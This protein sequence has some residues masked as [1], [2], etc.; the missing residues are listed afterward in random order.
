MK[1]K[2]KPLLKALISI[3]DTCDCQKAWGNWKSIFYAIQGECARAVKKSTGM[4]IDEIKA[5]G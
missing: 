1:A 5:N 2:I 4:T 3:S